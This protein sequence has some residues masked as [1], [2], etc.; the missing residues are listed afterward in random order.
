M[1]L[2]EDRGLRTVQVFGA[3]L[4]I[5]RPAAEGDD[6]PARVADRE[7]DPVA[8][9]VVGR[10]A[11]LRRD[12][13]A[14]LHQFARPRA[15]G[16]QIVLQR[17]APW[18]REAQAETR[19]VLFRQAAAFQIGAGVASGRTAQ[20]RLEPLGRQLQP[21]GEPLADLLVLGGARIDRGQRHPGLGRQALHRLDE[22]QALGLLQERDDVAALAGREVEELALVVV[23]VEGRRLLLGERRQADE[24]AALPAQLH[25]LADHVRGTEAGLDLVEEAFVEAH[26]HRY[27]LTRSAAGSLFVLRSPSR[28]RWISPIRRQK[29]CG[30]SMFVLIGVTQ[31][32]KRDHPRR[33]LQARPRELTRAPRRPMLPLPVAS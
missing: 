27:L 21:L 15:L 7:D 18:R 24:L 28:R 9:P 1:A 26:G 5:H 4:G 22:G 14:R 17:R 6:A 2:V 20:L 8:E 29:N 11:L 13:Q 3:G 16:D 31:G 32:V 12:Q 33:I 30:C 19:P 25:R 23:D 10:P